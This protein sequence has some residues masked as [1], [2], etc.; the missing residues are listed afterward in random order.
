MDENFEQYANK[1]KKQTKYSNH[2]KL[3][4]HMIEMRNIRMIKSHIERLLTYECNKE[5]VYPFVENLNQKLEH[6]CYHLENKIDILQR[7]DIRI[8]SQDIKHYLNTIRNNDMSDILVKLI[9]KISIDRII[10]EE[11]IKHEQ[12]FI[13]V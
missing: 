5:I 2:R 3:I 1:I 4:I 6:E 13:I 10:M 7:N 12:K 9:N 11:N 8:Y